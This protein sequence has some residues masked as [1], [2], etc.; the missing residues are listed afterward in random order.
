MP[1]AMKMPPPGAAGPAVGD[2]QAR[3]RDGGIAGD[4][5]DPADVLPLTV[6][7][8]APGPLIVTLSVMSS[9]PLVR[10]MVP[11]TAKSIVI[12]SGVGVGGGDRRPQRAGAAVEEVGHRE[13]AG[14]AA[15][16]EGFDAGAAACAGDGGSVG[17]SR[18]TDGTSG[19]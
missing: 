13:G 11:V 18:P 5:E 2:R 19:T 8:L 10:A 17:T 1:P 7:A 9:W 4:A 12:G 14:Q 16:V 15:V 6:R 3:D